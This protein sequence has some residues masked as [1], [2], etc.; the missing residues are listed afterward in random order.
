MPIKTSACLKGNKV[1]VLNSIFEANSTVW[2][3][4]LRPGARA[5]GGG[6]GGIFPPTPAMLPTTMPESSTAGEFG[7]AKNKFAE[8]TRQPA[9]M[10]LIPSALITPGKE[11]LERWPP[12]TK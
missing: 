11:P 8:L 7:A 2:V 12:I 3:P 6:E 4:G 1:S 9:R 10:P 5:A